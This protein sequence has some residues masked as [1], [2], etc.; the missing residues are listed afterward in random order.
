MTDIRLCES[1]FWWRSRHSY[2]SLLLAIL[3]AYGF[4]LAGC[5]GDHAESI[6][7]KKDLNDQIVQIKRENKEL[8][9]EV[10]RAKKALAAKEAPSAKEAF[11]DKGAFA[12]SEKQAEVLNAKNKKTFRSRG[13]S[14]LANHHIGPSAEEEFGALVQA[15]PEP[16][17]PLGSADVEQVPENMVIAK[18]KPSGPVEEQLARIAEEA[19]AAA[20]AGLEDIYFEFDSWKITE[21]GKDVLEK[22]AILLKED[23]NLTLLIEGHCDQRGSHAY[24]IILGKK[25]AIAIRDYLVYL[26][27]EPRRLFVIT[28]GKEKPFCKRETEACYQ[29]NRRG[30]LLVRYL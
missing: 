25:R 15:T 29:E 10:A 11:A 16:G 27:V 26:G 21:S 1:T 24:N 5:A 2:L 12:E 7:S 13:E 20:V 17:D 14:D 3:G 19:F 23:T 28:Y 18:V 8:K 4:L 30:H 9:A 22:N 6:R